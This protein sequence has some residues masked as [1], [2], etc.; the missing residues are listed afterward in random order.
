MDTDETRIVFKPRISADETQMEEKRKGL[1]Q[2][3]PCLS[4]LICISSALIRG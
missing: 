3:L 1:E 4:L 2:M